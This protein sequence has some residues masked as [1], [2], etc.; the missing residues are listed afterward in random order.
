MLTSPLH[1]SSTSYHRRT[2]SRRAWDLARCRE[3]VA[4]E[5]TPV[6][7]MLDLGDDG[8]GLELSEVLGCTRVAARRGVQPAA[9]SRELHGGVA[10]PG[11]GRDERFD[12]VV[13]A[14]VLHEVYSERG[15]GRRGVIDHRAGT[16]AVRRVL[17]TVSDC[18]GRRGGVLVTDDVLC[19]ELVPVVVRARTQAALEAVRLMAEL[20]VARPVDVRFDDATTFVVGSRDLCVLLSEYEAVKNGRLGSW[21]RADVRRYMTESDYRRSFA[22]LGFVTRACLGTPGADLAAEER[23]FEILAGLPTFPAR[24]IALLASR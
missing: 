17:G 13:L 19:D 14:D 22:Q 6:E 11:S 10:P 5:P 2:E 9:G 16:E 24:R 3:L 12:L 18:V 4:A 8:L 23:D 7:S 15:R 20:F 21:E 1:E